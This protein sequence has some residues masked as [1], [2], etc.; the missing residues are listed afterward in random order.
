LDSKRIKQEESNGVLEAEDGRAVSRAEL[1]CPEL[2]A[3]AV[4]IVCCFCSAAFSDVTS[5]QN[6]TL[7]NHQVK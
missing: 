5:L 7:Q 6:H 4:K 1:P 3:Q 2:V